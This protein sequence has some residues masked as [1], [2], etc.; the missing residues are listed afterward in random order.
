MFFEPLVRMETGPNRR[1]SWFRFFSEPKVPIRFDSV[2]QFRFFWTPLVL[3]FEKSIFCYIESDGHFWFISLYNLGCMIGNNLFIF[4]FSF[5]YFLISFL[6]WKREFQCKKSKLR[7]KLFERERVAKNT[8]AWELWVQEWRKFM[9]LKKKSG[10]F[11]GF[12]QQQN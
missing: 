3:V 7:G 2:H 8:W 9:F 12:N 5:G 11:M 1:S 4:N 6:F 10:L